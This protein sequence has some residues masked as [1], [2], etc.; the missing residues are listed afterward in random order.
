[1]FIDA[2][3]N[4]NLLTDTKENIINPII[5]NIHFKIIRAY[6]K[7]QEHKI[8]NIDTSELVSSQIRTK[9]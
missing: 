3:Y 6:C 1:M 2:I 9:F 4:L 5:I 7:L 8:N